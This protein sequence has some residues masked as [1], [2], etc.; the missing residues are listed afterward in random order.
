M[1]GQVSP[2]KWKTRR[3]HACDEKTS[4]KGVK[5][6]RD[7]ERREGG[8]KDERSDYERGAIE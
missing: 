7:G 2:V 6:V 1:S 5:G 3:P 8:Y 4:R